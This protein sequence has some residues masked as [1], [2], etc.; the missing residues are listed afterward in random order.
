MKPVTRDPNLPHQP[1][2]EKAG[3]GT[4]IFVTCN[5]RRVRAGIAY[6]YEPIGNVTNRQETKELY[7]Q[8][9]V[10]RNLKV[11]FTPEWEIHYKDEEP[12]W[13]DGM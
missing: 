10:H 11:P 4:S 2:L 8:P 7:N 6:A 1:I 13:R 12:A 9:G 5:C 3:K